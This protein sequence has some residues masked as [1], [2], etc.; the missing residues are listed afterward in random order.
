MKCDQGQQICCNTFCLRLTAAST[1]ES[2]TQLHLPMPPNR[3][4]SS[5]GGNLGLWCFSVFVE[6]IQK[7]SSCQF[8]ECAVW[9]HRPTEGGFGGLQPTWCDVLFFDRCKTRGCQS[10]RHGAEHAKE[11]C[12]TQFTHSRAWSLHRAECVGFVLRSGL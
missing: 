4:M 3:N 1:N 12:C 5:L 10:G 6:N 11:R 8:L 7:Q 2:T 9:S